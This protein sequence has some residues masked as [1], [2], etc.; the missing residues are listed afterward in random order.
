MRS[1]T[2]NQAGHARQRNQ[3]PLGGQGKLT[4]RHLQFGGTA[5]QRTPLACSQKLLNPLSFQPSDQSVQLLLTAPPG[6]S[7]IQV[8]DPHGE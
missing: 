8:K 7:G 6:G 5:Y 2:S 3:V 1:E 4:N